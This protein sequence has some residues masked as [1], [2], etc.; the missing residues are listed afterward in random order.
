MLYFGYIGLSKIILLKLIYLILLL[1]NLKL[2]SHVDY[3][4]IGQN[5]SRAKLCFLIILMMMGFHFL[6][7]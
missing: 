2:M 1:A 5:Y 4:S 7:V 6:I 3:I